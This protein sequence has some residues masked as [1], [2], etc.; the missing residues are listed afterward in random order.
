MESRCPP[1]STQ[2]TR[3]LGDG[4]VAKHSIRPKP[5]SFAGF[6]L[7]LAAS[8]RTRSCIR[9]PL[10]SQSSRGSRPVYTG[11][12]HQTCHH[13]GSVA[14]MLCDVTG[15]GGTREAPG[16]PHTLTEQTAA[17]GREIR[18]CVPAASHRSW[19]TR[20]ACLERSVT[21]GFVAAPRDNRVIGYKLSY[22]KSGV[23]IHEQR[24]W[25]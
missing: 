10:P 5:T 7:G 15:W 24:R 12:R 22:S 13:P 2:G 19:N 20:E 1:H 4:D 25:F 8:L 16:P 23:I 14:L 11:S 17:P 6:S 18:L 3:G 21:T 9:Q